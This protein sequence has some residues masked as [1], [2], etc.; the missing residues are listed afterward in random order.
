MVA[1]S[2]C[3]SNLELKTSRAKKQQNVSSVSAP[4]RPVTSSGAARVPP[5]RARCSRR[6]GVPPAWRRA[7]RSGGAWTARCPRRRRARERARG[8]TCRPTTAGTSPARRTRTPRREDLR[9][10]RISNRRTRRCATALPPSQDRSPRT[11]PTRRTRTSP[12]WRAK[13]RST[14]RCASPSGPLP[15]RP[16]RSMSAD[17]KRKRVVSFVVSPDANAET[18]VPFGRRR[19]SDSELFSTPLTRAADPLPARTKK[20]K[21]RTNKHTETG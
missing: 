11:T 8:A 14:A 1:M 2:G 17:E 13:P 3:G 15:R 19:Y 4:G 9:G 6:R 16:A 12:R 7:C 5:K 18:R 10:W 21:N 20:K